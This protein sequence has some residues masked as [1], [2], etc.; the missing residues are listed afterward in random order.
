MLRG[1]L[2]PKE[3]E[4]VQEGGSALEMKMPQVRNATFSLI[5][6]KENWPLKI[7]RLCGVPNKERGPQ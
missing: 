5:S 3:D 4:S 2:R 1:P 6:T 7:I